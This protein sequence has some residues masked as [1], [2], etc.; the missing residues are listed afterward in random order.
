MAEEQN[1]QDKTE[2]DFVIA[3]RHVSFLRHMK[4]SPEDGLV[5]LPLF[6]NNDLTSN[7]NFMTHIETLS[8]AP[9]I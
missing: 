2:K 6:A 7:L 9:P 4:Q 1:S 5:H 3:G 8:V